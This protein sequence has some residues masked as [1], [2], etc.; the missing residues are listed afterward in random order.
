MVRLW[1]RQLSQVD[2]GLGSDNVLAWAQVPSDGFL[3]GVTGEIHCTFLTTRIGIE[4]ATYYGVKGVMVASPSPDDSGDNANEMWDALVDKDK[5]FAKGALDID[6]SDVVT[7]SFIEPGEPNINAL[8]D[9]ETYDEAGE[10]YSRAKLMTYMGTRS[11]FDAATEP[12]DWLPADAFKVR[13]SKRRMRADYHSWAMIAFGCPAMDDKQTTPAAFGGEAQ[14]A[15][16]KYVEMVLEQAF[17]HL[18]GLTEV[19]AE[20]PWEDAA[21]MLE[22]YIEPTVYEATAS[23]FTQTTWRVFGMH[24]WDVSVPGHPNFSS[25]SAKE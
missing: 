8:M 24:T 4:T 12:G 21:A 7:E 18:I 3:N 9:M 19:G 11:G 16:L 5:D 17:T 25:I 6:P 22:A 14:W 10:F 15:Q 13:S 1:R 2:V 23:S 20:T